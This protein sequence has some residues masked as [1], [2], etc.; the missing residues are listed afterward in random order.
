MDSKVEGRPI[1]TFR[2]FYADTAV[3][4]APHALRC[5]YDFFG[6]EHML[7]ASDMPF[8]PAPGQFIRDTIADVEALGLSATERE[9]LFEGNARK[10]LLARV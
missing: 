7:F 9:Q 4:G 2:K 6:V 5:A 10:L 8:D 1:D 3:F